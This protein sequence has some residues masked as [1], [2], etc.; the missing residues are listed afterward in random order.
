MKKFVLA[1]GLLVLS[2]TVFADIGAASGNYSAKK[3]NNNLLK[4]S[5]DLQVLINTN[6]TVVLSSNGF[7]ELNSLKGK[8][9]EVITKQPG[10]Y[11]L[12]AFPYML[13]I[14]RE[15]GKISGDCSSELMVLVGGA[16]GSSVS[17]TE[18][19]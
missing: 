15:S 2:T 14:T 5:K 13:L 9:L 12:K 10:I 3:W 11:A 6:G 7:S 17:C 16:E 18:K 4:E 8:S 19:L 1:T